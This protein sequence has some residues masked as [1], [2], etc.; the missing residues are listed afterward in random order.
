MCSVYGE[1]LFCKPPLYGVGESAWLFRSPKMPLG[2]VVISS[3]HDDIHLE[4]YYAERLEA[5]VFSLEQRVLDT[6][7]RVVSPGLNL[8][9]VVSRNYC[10][11]PMD[12]FGKKASRDCSK[13]CK[14]A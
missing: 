8:E 14:H 2:V 1:R 6:L 4:R 11:C 10:N 7:V 3:P 12:A 5:D 13:M 9:P